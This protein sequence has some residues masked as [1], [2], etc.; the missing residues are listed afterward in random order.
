MTGANE[1]R[2]E[3][4]SLRRRLVRNTFWNQLALGLRML[5]T[6]VVLRYV[7]TRAGPEQAGIYFLALS[8]TGYFGIV[9]AALSP[10]LVKLVAEFRAKGEPAEISAV[11]RA[12][13]RIYVAGGMVAAAALILIALWALPLLRIAPDLRAPATQTLWVAALTA[14]LTT[15]LAAYDHVLRGCQR[16]DLVSFVSLG[17]SISSSLGQLAAAA[18]GL[19]APGLMSVTGACLLAGGLVSRWLARKEEP[20]VAIRAGSLR[21]AWR[22]L[23]RFAG[24]LLAITL[25]DLFI[26]HL[27]RVLAA[28][29]AGVQAV[30]IYEYAAALH[31]VPRDVH[32]MVVAA[33]TPAAS[34]LEARGERAKL[35]QMVIEASRLVVAVTVPIAVS[36][37]ALSPSVASSWAPPEAL[38]PIAI[39]VSYWILNANTGVISNV[40]VGIGKLKLLLVYA[41]AV[42]VG[43]LLASIALAR[44][45]GV[46]GVVA[47][48]TLT[49]LVGF[50]FALFFALRQIGVSVGAYLRRVFWPAYPIAA[51]MGVVVFAAGLAIRQRHNFVLTV[52]A[53]A[54]GVMGCYLAFGLIGVEAS[55]R[56]E[57]LS[58]IPFGTQ[59]SKTLDRVGAKRIAAKGESDAD[60]CPTRPASTAVP[61]RRP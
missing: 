51:I 42:A 21:L 55:E 36:I 46:S 19:G 59:L 22:R 48:T 52:I 7:V 30:A 27:D 18:Y 25:T 16:Y 41:Y 35:R 34:E 17:V 54:L 57:F 53:G 32:T 5:A 4:T 31:K 24:V 14:A 10:P 29:F 1:Y 8:F 43:N 61:E 6:L 47:G 23:A 12:A 38:A 58:A 3:R 33:I 20:S 2:T 45:F 60:G 15:P 26:Y 44:R 28:I 40:L 56:R 50:P 39:Y 13:H 9:D 11:F 37:V 49:Y